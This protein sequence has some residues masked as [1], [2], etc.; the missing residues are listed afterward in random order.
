ML[1]DLP[2]A[3]LVRQLG[4][5]GRGGRATSRD[6]STAL[7]MIQKTEEPI[8]T[9]GGAG[10][11]EGRVGDARARAAGSR[12]A[13]ARERAVS[14]ARNRR[15]VAAPRLSP[16]RSRSRRITEQVSSRNPAPLPSAR[17]PRDLG[18]ASGEGAADGQGSRGAWRG[19][20]A[21]PSPSPGRSG[22]L[23][24]RLEVRPARP[25]A[26]MKLWF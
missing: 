5:A 26:E 19:A 21:S 8:G 10:R 25:A 4:G 7:G 1:P 20:A 6:E 17:S 2:P 12:S 3:E 13:R 9:L 15:R 24:A 22:R 18:E 14:R 11:G 16:S 23:L